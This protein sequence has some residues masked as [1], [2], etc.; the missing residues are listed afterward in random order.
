MSAPPT[1][2]LLA[3]LLALSLSG[4]RKGWCA[5]QGPSSLPL[6]WISIAPDDVEVTPLGRRTTFAVQLPP[7]ASPARCIEVRFPRALEAARVEALGTGPNHAFTRLSE[8]RVRGNTL[9]LETP[10]LTLLRLDLVVHHHLRSP[11]LPPQVR[12]GAEVRP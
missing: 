5:G 7:E 10:P 8:T 12:V 4:C 11:P 9:V 1:V 2:M 3:A 6:T